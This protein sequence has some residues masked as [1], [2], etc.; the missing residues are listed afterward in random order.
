MD[1]CNVSVQRLIGR[2]G[3]SPDLVVSTDG[4][5]GLVVDSEKI[6]SA[7][8]SLIF[9][10]HLHSWTHPYGR[11]FD[12]FISTQHSYVKGMSGRLDGLSM[13]LPYWV[14]GNDLPGQKP[15]AQKD[16]DIDVAFVGCRGK[17]NQVRR[18]AFL[19]KLQATLGKGRRVHIGP[20]SWSEVYRGSRVVIN[21]PVCDDL[22]IR[23]FE[24][25]ASG[26]VLVSP[27]DSDGMRELFEPEKDFV[28]YRAW[29]A[30]HAAQRIEEVLSR[31]GRA[32]TMA[33]RA[34]KKTLS[35]HLEP[36]RAEDL[37]G[38]LATLLRHTV[39]RSPDGERVH[40]SALS[41]IVLA[42]E[43][44][45]VQ[46]AK[47][48]EW[49][50]E[51]LNLAREKLESND[52]ASE[53]MKKEGDFLMG[54]V[55]HLQGRPAEALRRFESAA[56]DPRLEP[57]ALYGESRIWRNL[58]D[59]ARANRCYPR[60]LR[61]ASLP[62]PIRTY[63]DLLLNAF[64]FEVKNYVVPVQGSSGFTVMRGRAREKELVLSNLAYA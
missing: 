27:A 9:D 56:R 10:P 47:W 11:V 50:E 42:L 19:D 28:S 46:A 17:P 3:R 52:G 51:R 32:Q 59:T 37:C 13:W 7:S 45:I 62:A 1:G 54:L 36:H 49:F 30:E 5:L 21:V 25:M 14:Q 34:F 20:G 29:D 35:S 55:H 61:A 48:S 60:G 23:G 31:P 44:P 43:A 12:H 22:N 4:D 58:G 24:A 57:I 15:T 39:S 40:R 26:A 63:W 8:V 38:I 2:I 18:D 64:Q 33:N 6:E 41:L 16:R 53:P